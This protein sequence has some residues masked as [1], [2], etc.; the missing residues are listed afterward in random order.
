MYNPEAAKKEPP[1]EATF[2]SE[3]TEGLVLA[4]FLTI[5][6]KVLQYIFQNYWKSPE[7]VIPDL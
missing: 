3:I 4:F 1:K 7:S 6:V 5:I 2:L